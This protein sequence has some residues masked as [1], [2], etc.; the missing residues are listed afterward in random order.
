MS[1]S[2]GKKGHKMQTPG[3]TSTEKVTGATKSKERGK[4]METMS[5]LLKPVVPQMGRGGIRS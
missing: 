4:S 3:K 1:F 2:S 5:K